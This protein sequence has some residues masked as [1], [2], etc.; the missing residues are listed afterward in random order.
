MIRHMLFFTFKSEVSGEERRALVNDLAA[1]PERFPRMIGMQI[2]PNT[3]RRDDSFSHGMTV[4]FE[5]ETE[6]LDYLNS[7]FHEDFVRCRFRPLI[8]ARAIVTLTV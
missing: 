2:G 3:S 1:L 7:E 4:S 6:L 8:A 5:Q